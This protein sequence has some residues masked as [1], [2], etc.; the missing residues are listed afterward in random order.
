MTRRNS[1]GVRV[2]ERR[3][4]SDHGVVDPHVDRPELRLDARRGGLDRVGVGDVGGQRR[5]RAARPLVP[6]RQRPRAVL[7]AGDQPDVVAARA[8]ART[9]AR[10]TPADAPVTAM[11]LPS[12][13]IAVGLPAAVL[14][15]SSA[16]GAGA[17]AAAAA[18]AA[19]G[20]VGDDAARVIALEADEEMERPR[21]ARLVGVVRWPRSPG[22]R[23]SR[24]AIA[25]VV[26]PFVPWSCPQ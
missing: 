13:P 7:A 2:P 20:G 21:A 1:S 18:T 4:D 19:S 11:T 9:V 22:R 6:R 17:A 15:Y 8:N 12:S 10:P 25:H 3:E 5:A 16:G 26:E 24:P 23:T 14:L